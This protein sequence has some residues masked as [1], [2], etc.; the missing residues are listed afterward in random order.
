LPTATDKFYPDFVVRLKDGRILVVEYN[1]TR[2]WTNA[3]S[4]EKRAIGELWAN[5]SGEKCLFFMPSGPQWSL[6]AGMVR[7]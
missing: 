7:G 5:Q 3:D 2:D 6:L 1:S 4:Q